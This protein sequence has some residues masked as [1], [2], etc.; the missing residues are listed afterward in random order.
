M[1]TKDI[2]RKTN[3]IPISLM[4]INAKIQSKIPANVIQQ[5]I[6]KN[7]TPHDQVGFITEMQGWLNI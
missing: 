7:Y 6:K 5:C 3:Y 2:A 1:K 4:N